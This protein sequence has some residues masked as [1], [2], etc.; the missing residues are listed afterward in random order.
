MINSIKD[1]PCASPLWP[2]HSIV[3][4]IETACQFLQWTYKIKRIDGAL[5][6]ERSIRLLLRRQLGGAWTAVDYV[7]DVVSRV[8]LQAA[9]ELQDA[10][11]RTANE[12]RE[13]GARYVIATEICLPGQMVAN[14]R[15]CMVA[16]TVLAERPV[17]RIIDTSLKP[18]GSYITAGILLR[19]VA[20]YGI[21]ERTVWAHLK[22]LIASGHV[23]TDLRLP[24]GPATLL[25]SRL[26]LL[27]LERRHAILKKKAPMLHTLPPWS[28]CA[29]WHS[30]RDFPSCP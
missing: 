28:H 21:P 30:L 11:R 4:G 25:R 13:R 7:V 17:Q 26:P 22:A 5:I 20:A 12:T 27:D 16:G 19:R 24:F 6:P 15:S 14:M 18:E 1:R 23:F 10:A 29:R 8:D 3:T 2:G 9:V